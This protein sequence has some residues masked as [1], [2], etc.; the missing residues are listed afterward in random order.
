GDIDVALKD[1][2]R[3]GPI[4]GFAQ[5]L[6]AHIARTYA[7]DSEKVGSPCAL[8]DAGARGGEGGLVPQPLRD[9]L[10]DARQSLDHDERRRWNLFVRLAR[11]LE[12]ELGNGQFDT[13]FD[14]A[15]GRANLIY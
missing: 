2:T 11:E 14:R 15:S 9:A 12:P 8:L 1:P 7:L 5:S 3:D 4:V 13:A 10:F 6:R